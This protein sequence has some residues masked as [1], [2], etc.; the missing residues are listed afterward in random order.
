VAI[1]LSDVSSDRDNNFNL[2]RFVAASMVVI[3]HSYPLTGTVGGPLHGLGLSLG[4]IAVDIFFVTSGF[5]ITRS[6]VTRNNLLAF[7]IARVLRIYP[8]LIVSVLFCVFVVGWY[9]TK[10]TT[11]LY[12]SNSSIFSF[13]FN[14]S[15][16]IAGPLHW[17]L[18]GVFESNPFKMAVNGSLWT[19]PFEIKMY[20]L[21]AFLGIP[22]I[23]P[24]LL[25]RK[26]FTRLII[27]IAF[28]LMGGFL[29]NHTMQYTESFE[30]IYTSRLG[31]QF[32]IGGALYLMKDHVLLY[33]RA[34]F[35]C[36]AVLVYFSDN[37]P[38]LMTLYS[39][40]IAYLVIYLA[41]AP[42]RWARTFNH[43]GDYSY[44][45]YIY[46]FPIQQMISA[47]IVGVSATTM[48]IIAWP[49][50]LILAVFSWHIIEKPILEKKGCHIALQHYF[51]RLPFL[52]K[53][54]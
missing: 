38:V 51:H 45:V 8:A 19:L 52:Q 13:I 16:L 50:T 4:H 11:E 47:L 6:L 10:H 26:V 5:L 20:A 32:F 1:L 23:S 2:I 21:L 12:L 44:G 24:R 49:V 46:A 7:I 37:P 34:F 3:H 17:N 22:L 48:T 42:S 15:L 36:L 40:V 43:L 9:F 35:A 14:N 28:V 30:F 31:G 41:Y 29:I 54:G 25:S 53:K 39:L 33:G 18:P 27:I